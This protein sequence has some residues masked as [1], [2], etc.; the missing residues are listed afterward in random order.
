MSN[1]CVSE[2]GISITSNPTDRLWAR[3]GCARVDPASCACRLA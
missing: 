2:S 3:P 1:L